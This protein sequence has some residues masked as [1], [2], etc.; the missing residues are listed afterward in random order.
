MTTRFILILLLCG[1]AAVGQAAQKDPNRDARR[2]L[3]RERFLDHF[4]L[5][6]EAPNEW[7][8]ETREK[9]GCRWDFKAQYLSGGAGLPEKPFWLLNGN[10]PKTFIDG[11]RKGGVTAWLTFYALAASAP[12]RYKPG[13]AEATVVNAKVASTMKSYFELFKTFVEGAGK[14]APTPVMLQIEPDEWCHLLLSANMDPAKVDVKVGSCGMEELKGLP[15]NLFGWA[16]AF[17]RLRDLYAPVNVMLGCNPSAF[18]ANGTM[19]GQKMG[20]TMKA[21][22]G[23]WDF[24]VHETCDRD[25]GLEGKSPPYGTEIMRCGNL[26]NHLKWTADFHA[27]SGLYV[28]IWQVAAGN[29]Y[30][31]TCNNTPGH[32]CD[33]LA[34]MLLEDYPKNPTIS[35][36]IKS[37]CIGWV[38][39]G[40]QDPS[41]RVYDY[42]K[43]GITNPPAIPGNL[44]NKSEYADDDGGYLRLRGGAYYRKPAPILGK[45]AAGAKPPPAEPA[46]TAP[47]PAKQT[48]AG[49]ATPTAIAAWDAKLRAAVAEDIKGGRKIRFQLKVVGQPAEPTAI[50]DDGVLSV[51]SD[52]G[53]FPCRWV[54]LTLQDRRNLAVARI[55]DAKPS[56]DLCLAAFYQFACGDEAAAHALL[57]G[58]SAAEVEEV[59]GSFKAP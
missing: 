24:A 55:R 28:F 17:K 6:V 4:S 2:K 1:S 34:Q 49:P 13:P 39:L 32:Y 22:A 23:D 12:A 8:I 47:T 57:K 36:Y 7:I 59:T 58:V 10:T 51:R 26:E 27:A 42:K 40:G 43:D 5:G 20:V 30:F 21:V 54:D 56:A 25:K 35:R 38:F 46:A 50:D 15:D 31:A 9:N 53:N 33:N 37:G 18:D 29:T 14:E 16:S 44:G 19:T 48:I 52:V 41:T 3:F 45:A 11:A